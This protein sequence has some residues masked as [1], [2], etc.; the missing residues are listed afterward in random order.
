VAA[1][2]L[3]PLLGYGASRDG[4]FRLEDV[5]PG[6]KGIGKTCYQG[7]KPEEFQVEILGIMRG[8]SSGADAILARFS[9]GA[10]DQAGV[11]EGMS[12]SPVYIDGKLLGAVAFSYEF[13]K[14]AIGGITPISEMIDAFA[15]SEAA[16]PSNPR[17]IL[18]KSMLWDYKA[19]LTPEARWNTNWPSARLSTLLQSARAPFGEHALIP[20]A[21]P[22]STGG[23]SPQT[24]Q[25]FAPGFRSL[26]LSFLQG[27]GGGSTRS[28]T[29]SKAD[30]SDN[31]P[32]EPG[33]NL[34]V[35]LVRG[36]LDVSAAGT[37]TYVDGQKLY[38]FGHMLFDLG[39]TELPMHKGRTLAIFP[40]LQSS[41]KIVETGES[42]GT[43]GQ[44]RSSGIYGMIGQNAKMIPLS[45]DITTSRGIKKSLKFEVA[46]DRFLAPLLI[47]LTVYDSI[48]ASEREIGMQTLSVKGTIDIKG[49]DPVKI[50]NRFS[51]ESSAPSYASLSIASPLNFLMASGFK[52]LNVENISITIDSQE[53]D[54][55]AVL[56]S[57]R[58]DRTELKAGE[59]AN[60][61]ILYRK[62]DGEIL[63]D[64]YPIKM[65]SD[66]PPGRFSVLVADGT[67]LM[68]VDAEEQGGDVAPRGLGQMIKYIN[69][70]RKNDRLYI[71]LFRKEAGAVV[72]GEGLPGLPPSILSI[73]KSER[74]AGG[75]SAIQTSPY[76]EYEMPSLDYV[77]TGS[78]TLTLSIQP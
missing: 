11:F 76:M 2:V 67:T 73:L 40:G 1:V 4:F 53:D 63:Q 75:M 34:V 9:G 33:S 71:R 25:A 66:L 42:V 28:G 61:D 5:R 58:V 56:D 68:S 52:D 20:I 12:G 65:P 69:N 23:F 31:A 74:S 32:L 3:W 46:H 22:L 24:L 48:I 37:V 15:G 36:D 78:K 51:S 35:S 55:A 59:T 13:S 14:E 10:L 26:G 17:I 62:A 7:S 72:K 16:L 19:A 38:A 77:I 29:S 57:I 41:F 27:S 60:V 43:I 44:D 45:V 49:E 18:K 8:V 39:F 21:T 47:N 6:M 64:S 70:I 54:R 30:S 50:E